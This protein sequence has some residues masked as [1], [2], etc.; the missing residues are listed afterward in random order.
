MVDEVPVESADEDAPTPPVEE[1]K[2]PPKKK[3]QNFLMF[4]RWDLSEVA[5]KDM[6]LRK[7]INLDPIYT[8]HTG[9]RHA[10][11]PFAKQKVNIVE[12]LIN[13]MMKSEDYTGKKSK[14][15]NVVKDAFEIINTKTKQNP[16]QVLVTGI[17]RAAPREEVT[18]LKYGGISVPKAVDVAPSRRL[19]VALRNIAIGATTASFKNPKPVAQ[20]LADEII[21]ASKGEMESAAVARKEELERVAKSA[22]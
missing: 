13:V 6:S 16:V 10:N 2:A 21:K 9:A 3:T 1:K 14:A 8:P 22:R 11:R 5:V 18:R 20:C 4:G 19:D 12:R 7:Y 17:E 15:Y